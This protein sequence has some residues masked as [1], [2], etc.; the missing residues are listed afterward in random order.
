LL[1]AVLTSA[2]FLVGRT[3]MGSYLS[4]AAVVSRFGA[5]GSVVVFLMWVYYSAQIFLLGVEFTQVQ[6]EDRGRPI[7]PQEGA[8]RVEQRMVSGSD[9]GRSATR[10]QCEER[11]GADP[12][13][14]RRS[15]A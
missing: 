15:G 4:Q 10:S 3:G 7:R 6:A 14:N 13:T 12:S 11:L 2:L 9:R 1:G 5:A 8:R